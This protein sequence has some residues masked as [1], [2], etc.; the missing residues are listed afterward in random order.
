MYIDIKH[1]KDFVWKEVCMYVWLKYI[2]EQKL[3]SFLLK[4]NT[5]QDAQPNSNF[6]LVFLFVLNKC[7][8]G[9]CKVLTYLSIDLTCGTCQ[10]LF[11][12]HLCFVM[13]CCV[14]GLTHFKADSKLAPRDVVTKSDWAQT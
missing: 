12:V 6:H 13:L 14:L 8:V 11:V 4:P 1:R 7:P 5:V 10:E 9:D 3:Y 2:F